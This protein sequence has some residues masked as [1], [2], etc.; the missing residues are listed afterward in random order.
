[1]APPMVRALL[2]ALLV[3]GAGAAADE[4]HKAWKDE[5]KRLDRFEQKYWREFQK[6]FTEASLT[7]LKP[8]EDADAR[9]NDAINYALDHTG[10]RLLYEDYALIE[11]GRGKADVALAAS[12]DPKALDELFDALL[13][14]AKRIDGLEATLADAKPQQRGAWYEQ[15][16]PVE[17]HGVAVRRDAL[18]RALA[19]APGAAAFLAGEGMKQAAKRDGKRSI[20]RRVAVLDALG[21]APGDDARAALEPFA[22]APESSLR[23]V[24]AE[25]LLGRG[26]AARP[27][28][29]PLLKDPSAPVRRAL[30]QGIAT[31][32]AGDPGWIAPVL[33]CHADAQGLARD[34]CV[35]ALEALTNQRFGDAH[36]LWTEWFADYK[37]EILGGKFKKE[38]IEVREV[39]R[40]PSPVACSFYTIATPSRA[41][42]FIVEGSRRIFWPADLDVQLQRYKETWHSQHRAWEDRWPSHLAILLREFDRMSAAFVPDLTFAV[43]APSAPCVLEPLGGPKLM[44]A[45]KRDFRAV[46][47]DLERFDGNEWCAPYE[48]LVAA[49]RIAGL[50]PESDADFPAAR[51]DTIYL[52]DSGGSTGG[53]YMTP[54]ATIAAFRRFN[55]FRRLVVHTIRVCD[56]GPPSEELLKGLAEASGG[57]YHWAKKPPE[58][59]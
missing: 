22:A 15:R 42:L 48:A 4:G 40:V 28:L 11:E 39:P 21:L 17:R 37:G 7:L 24:A 33:A 43:L 3:L 23:L 2:L 9:P 38:A 58:V 35:R 59:P 8:R 49:A 56:E 16:P 27:A 51:A 41:V 20:V 6:R 32:G 46:R 14:V 5:Q 53:R 52:W 26:A 19:Q 10:I 31:A 36:A 45:D 25:A 57:T 13:D 55:R 29:E 34:D 44:R 12:G 1:M 30:L 50:G 47:H 54:I 18:V